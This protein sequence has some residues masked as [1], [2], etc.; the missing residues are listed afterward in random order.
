MTQTNT[1]RASDDR[2]DDDAVEVQ[3]IPGLPQGAKS[4]PSSHADPGSSV[5]AV[6]KDV[7]VAQF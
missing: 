6:L 5:D 7:P 2:E 1:S 3:T 4:V